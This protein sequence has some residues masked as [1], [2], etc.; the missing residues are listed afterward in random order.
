M[1]NRTWHIPEERDKLSRKEVAELFLSQQGKCPL[2]GQKLQTKGHVPVEFI[3]EHM[4]PLWRKGTNDL[5]NRGLVCK[6]CAKTKT[7]EEATERA[8]AKRV[9]DK[10]ISAI[11]KSKTAMPF[12]RQD[13]R[14]KKLNGQV[15]DRYTGEPI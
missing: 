7:A 11:P 13:R 8:K 4:E 3:D 5:N 15:V 1:T 6:P 12:G 9:R 2:C 14:K 10:H